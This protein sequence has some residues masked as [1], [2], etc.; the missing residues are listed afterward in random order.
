MTAVFESRHLWSLT[1]EYRGRDRW[2]VRNGREC[3][4]RDGEWDFEPSP[5]NR[6]QDWITAHRFSLDEALVQAGRHAMA[7]TYRGITPQQI[8][9]ENED[10][11]HAA[12]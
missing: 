9:K 5:G 10:A 2:A 7:M 1:V 4:S 11:D 3:L 12:P 6:E 8:M